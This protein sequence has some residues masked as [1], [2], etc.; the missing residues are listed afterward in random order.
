MKSASV[1]IYKVMEHVTVKL[2]IVIFKHLLV[3]GTSLLP[4]LRWKL[5]PC[6]VCLLRAVFEE[7]ADH[8]TFIAKANKTS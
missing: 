8:G 2:Y 4:C 6:V 1:M 3:L 5:R 7:I